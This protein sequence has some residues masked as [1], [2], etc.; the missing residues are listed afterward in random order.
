MNEWN[1]NNLMGEWMN[2]R[3]NGWMNEFII[4]IY[5]QMNEWIDEWI[6]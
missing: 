3:M 2:E 6:N 4:I 5:E 1:H